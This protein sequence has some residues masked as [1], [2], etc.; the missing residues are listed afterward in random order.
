MDDV[1]VEN[2][3][4]SMPLPAVSRSITRESTWE[5]VHS[6]ECAITRASVEKTLL[7]VKILFS[8]RG[9]EISDGTL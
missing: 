4:V 5:P 2:E 3:F 8:L 9:I 1:L 6:I 7:S